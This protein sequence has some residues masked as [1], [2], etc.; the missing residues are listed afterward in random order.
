MKNLWFE[1][2]EGKERLIAA[3]ETWK[4]VY[5]CIDEFIKQCNDNKVQR[6]KEI[7]KENFDESKVQL[8]KSY[9]TRVWRQEDGR[10]RIDVGSHTEFFITDVPYEG[11]V[12]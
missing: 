7:Y 8:F 11:N 6:S 2:N 12:V 1:N 9:Y 10:W 5:H 3:V 4:D